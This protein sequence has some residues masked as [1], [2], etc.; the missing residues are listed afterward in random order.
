MI[1]IN[2]TPEQIERAKILYEFGV[3]NNSITNGESNIFG[4]MG[5]I[6]VLDH[7]KSQNKDIKHLPTYDYDFIIT[8]KKIDVKTK[9]VY[10]LD[11]ANVNASV[12]AFNTSQKCDYYIFCQVKADMS[13]GWILGYMPK[14]GFYENAFYKKTGET[15]TNGF[16]FKGSCY[17]MRIKD[18]LPL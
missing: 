10:N 9:K 8:G 5:E 7:Y 1:T 16:V 6:I 2:I 18:I 13:K 4:A 14:A 15:D 17:N 3:L 11:T 12:S